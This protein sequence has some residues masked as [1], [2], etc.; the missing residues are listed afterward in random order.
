[1]IPAQNQ[2]DSFGESEAWFSCRSTLRFRIVMI[3][4]WN[5]LNFHLELFL[6]INGD[7]SA[8]HFQ[9]PLFVLFLI[10]ESS[11]LICDLFL[12]TCRLLWI[13]LSIVNNPSC[14]KFILTH[15]RIRVLNFLCFLI[16]RYIMGQTKTLYTYCRWEHT[17]FAFAR[18]Q[19]IKLTS[20]NRRI[21]FVVGILKIKCSDSGIESI[22]KF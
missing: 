19:K 7:S 13:L 16:L 5:R 8:I 18:C 9:N 21:M 12:Y 10:P 20:G 15:E 14:R 6:L 1:M 11:V 17:K 22:N 2:L 3:P 4:K